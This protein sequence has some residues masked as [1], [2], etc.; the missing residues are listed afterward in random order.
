MGN[1]PGEK[2][3]GRCRLKIQWI[4]NKRIKMKEI[5]CMI[6]GHNDH[7]K[8]PEQVNGIYAV[9]SVHKNGIENPEVKVSEFVRHSN[10]LKRLKL[11]QKISC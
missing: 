5:T 1:P 6:Q 4:V 10:S 3:S 7:Y 11:P 2:E 8:T 9:A